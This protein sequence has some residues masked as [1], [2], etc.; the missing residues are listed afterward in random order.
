VKHADAFDLAMDVG[1]MITEKIR[2]ERQELFQ[3]RSNQRGNQLIVMSTP[4]TYK[5]VEQLIQDLDTTFAVHRETRTYELKYMD[6]T[7]MADALNQLYQEET[8]GM[9]YLFGYM[10]GGGGRRGYGQTEVNFVPQ[11]RTNSL[12]VIAS[13]TEFEFIERMIKELDVEVPEEN[14]APRVYHVVHTDAAEMATVLTN[15]FEGSAG[16]RTGASLEYT[17][18]R[19]RTTSSQQ[20]VGALY[21]KV[22]FV[23]YRNTNSIVAITNNPQNFSIIES[24]IKELDVLDPEATNMLV[25]QLQYADAL[26]VANYINNLLSEGPVARPGGSQQQQQRTTTQQPQRTT[27]GSSGEGSQQP[28]TQLVVDAIYPWQSSSRQ[29]GRAGEEERP[30]STLIGQV[31]IVPDSRSQKLIVA[32]P[33]I[34]FESLKQ[35]IEEIDKPEP[36]VELRTHIIRLDVEGQKRLGWRWMPPGGTVT[37]EELDNAFQAAATMGITET[38]NEMSKA[39]TLVTDGRAVQPGGGIFS[40]DIDIVLLLQLL[41]KNRNAT[42]IAQPQVTVNNNERGSIFVG[43]QVPFETG[44]VTS[45]EGRSAQTTVDYRDVGTRLEITPQINK[46]GR[47]VLQVIIENSRRKPE[48]LNG[49]V[50]TETQ[51]YE[52]KLTIEPGQKVWLGGLSEQRLDNIVRKFPLLGDIPYIGYLFQKM[53]K[54]TLD[55]RIYAIIEPTVIENPQQAEARVQTAAMEI[56]TLMTEQ[57]KS[58]VK[59]PRV[60]EE[61][62]SPS[63]AQSAR[64]APLKYEEL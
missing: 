12:M 24:L 27:G 3:I 26:Q 17:I 34:Y 11:T 21:G 1:S 60:V 50:I 13:P 54:V 44:S 7:D 20:G 47:V 6:A 10:S 29:P 25:I 57:G 42:V 55:S 59:L 51:N 46:Q 33:S 43:E 4:Q 37:A 30:I 63:A 22:R 40:A 14:I 48:A 35:L 31:R 5:M 61:L 45:T 49:R 16:R 41:I 32:A 28:T 9:R 8:R 38:W 58:G 62:T 19:P 36:Q 53:D 39:A 15:L 64:R 2:R 52:T 18:W 23:V 56:K